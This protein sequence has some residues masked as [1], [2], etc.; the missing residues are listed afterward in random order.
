MESGERSLITVG[1]GHMRAPGPQAA[2]RYPSG[3]LV[4]LWDGKQCPL[5]QVGW[6]QANCGRPSA[7]GN[8]SMQ[9]RQEPGVRITRKISRIGHKDSCGH[10]GE[11]LSMLRFLNVR[12]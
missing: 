8:L 12:H 9:H 3:L 11:G 10:E 5:G 7:Q 2:L 1:F 4:I 6:V